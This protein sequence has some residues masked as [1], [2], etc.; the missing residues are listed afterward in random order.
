MLISKCHFWYTSVPFFW[1]N[2]FKARCVT[3]SK[4]NE[5]FTDIPPPKLKKE[6]QA[7]KRKINYLSY[8][9][10]APVEVYE[11]LWRLTSVKA[12]WTWNKSY[13]NLFNKAKTLIKEGMYEVL[14]WNETTPVR[15]VFISYRA[16]GRTT[17]NQILNELSM[18]H[19][20]QVHHAETN[21]ICPQK[22][23]QCGN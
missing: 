19:N 4:K 16:K 6:L 11:P 10:P 20:T 8:C 1:Q 23:M 9:S 13:Q 15:D 7:F 2:Y 5:G 14:W 3:R 21:F 18:R 17:A 12:D 22:L